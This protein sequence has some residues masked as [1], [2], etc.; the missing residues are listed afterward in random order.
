MSGVS[1]DSG[2]SEELPLLAALSPQ[3]LSEALVSPRGT[4]GCCARTC[5]GFKKHPL[6]LVHALVEIGLL[7]AA[8]ILIDHIISNSTDLSQLQFQYSNLSAQICQLREDLDKILRITG[9]ITKIEHHVKAIEVKVTWAANQTLLL[10][11]SANDMNNRTQALLSDW[12][13][14]YNLTNFVTEEQLTT[15]LAGLDASTTLPSVF[16]VTLTVFS[17]IILA[18]AFS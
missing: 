1:L 5:Q 9:K 17:R 3:P 11:E 7:I 8:A 10:A 18:C 12:E 2:R 14:K 16:L 4:Q 15:V 6:K 13:E